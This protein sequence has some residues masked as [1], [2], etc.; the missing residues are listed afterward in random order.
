M[1]TM[2]IKEEVER[3]EQRE[4]QKK[5]EKLEKIKQKEKQKTYTRNN[6]NVRRFSYLSKRTRDF[7][8]HYKQEETSLL[9]NNLNLAKIKNQISAK[10]CEKKV[11]KFLEEPLYVE[12]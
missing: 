4:K 8:Q 3:M 7:A 12:K 10:E 11:K 5:L 2:M 1:I 6:E 9:I